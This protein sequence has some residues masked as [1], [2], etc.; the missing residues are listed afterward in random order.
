MWSVAY[1]LQWLLSQSTGSRAHGSAA[2]APQLQG[3]GSVVATHGLSRSTAHEILL[4]QGLNLCLLHWQA[5]S[6]PLSH[7]ESLIICCLFIHFIEVQLI[8]NV[9]IVSEVQQSDLV[10]HVYLFSYILF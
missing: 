3:T 6:L 2:V 8:D 9:V 7:R 5:D 10:T 4:D 1:S